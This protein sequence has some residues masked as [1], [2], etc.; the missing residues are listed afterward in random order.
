MA[1]P[2]RRERR[3]TAYAP[4]RASA[5]RLRA[6]MRA[7]GM[8]ASGRRRVVVVRAEDNVFAVTGATGLVGR[9]LVKR[10]ISKGDRVN[11]LTRDKAGARETLGQFSQ[12][13]FYSK[14]EWKDGIEGTKAVINL[15]GEPISTRWS[16]GVKQEIFDSRVNTTRY[17]SDLIRAAENKPEV[18]VSGSA[19][20]FYGT[21]LG[22]TFT[23]DSP[24]GS[25]FLAGVCRE[26][27]AAAHAASESGEGEGPRVVCLRTG[28][29]L[30]KEGGVL[31]KMIPL[32]QLFIGSPLG[33]GDQWMS[34]IHRDD[35]VS[36]IVE[37]VENKGISGP[38]NGTAPNPVVMNEFCKA[39]AEC[40][41]RPMFMPAVP[42]L[43]LQVLLGEGAILV[44]EGQKVVPEKAKDVGFKFKYETLGPA[45]THA[46]R[47]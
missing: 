19:I 40:L 24:C 6:P 30:S 28:L 46:T 1:S 42:D 8:R 29:V 20:G 45:L 31:E 5:R 36:L 34:W 7:S 33:A 2:L 21:S 3:G 35:L 26:W 23:E 18:F 44:L 10:L 27:E 47:F 39:L 4:R 22:A 37:S 15:A 12:L 41:G 17:L 38:I 9:Q 16:E 11:V 43:P 14:G 32:F 25:D 13:G